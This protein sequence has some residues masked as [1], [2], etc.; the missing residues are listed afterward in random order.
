MADATTKA[1]GAAV[2]APPRVLGTGEIARRA[3]VA[4][5]LVTYFAVAE[6]VPIQ[7]V[8]QSYLFHAADAH[9][10]VERLRDLNRRVER[11]RDQLDEQ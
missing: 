2:D 5:I 1:E 8:G 10:L 4:R 3:G 9:R 6:G 7:R 11:L